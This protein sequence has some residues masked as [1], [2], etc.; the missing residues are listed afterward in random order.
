MEKFAKWYSESEWLK[1]II[2]YI[3]RIQFFR[4]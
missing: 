4:L 3:K 1:F 2:L